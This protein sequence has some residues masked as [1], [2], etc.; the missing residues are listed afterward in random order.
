[1]YLYIFG[2]N[3][4]CYR[5][6]RGKSKI[7]FDAKRNQIPQN[8]SGRSQLQKQFP[9][10]YYDMIEPQKVPN[11]INKL[12]KVFSLNKFFSNHIHEMLKWSLSCLKHILKVHLTCICN[13]V[14]TYPWKK[15]FF[16][17]SS[18]L[19]FKKNLFFYLLVKNK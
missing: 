7:N 12:R 16:L 4:V 2:L 15:I 18:L 1:M 17:K 8:L 10:S 9:Q 11:R 5:N 6:F 14:V 13:F 19:F 3:F